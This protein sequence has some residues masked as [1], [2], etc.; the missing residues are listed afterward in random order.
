[1]ITPTFAFRLSVVQLAVWLLVPL[2]IVTMMVRSGGPD[3]LAGIAFLGLIV[4]VLGG[5]GIFAGAVG[6]AFARRAQRATDEATAQR[7]ARASV[8]A[9]VALGALQIAAFAVS[10]EMLTHLHH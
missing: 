2:S 3:N 8:I 9:N 1:M 5:V 7:W 4:A 10:F 6:L